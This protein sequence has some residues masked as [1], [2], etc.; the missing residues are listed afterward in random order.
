MHPALLVLKDL[1]SQNKTI[2]DQK[3]EQKQKQKKPTQMAIRAC[4]YFS[5]FPPPGGSQVKCWIQTNTSLFWLD[6]SYIYTVKTNFFKCKINVLKYSGGNCWLSGNHLIDLHNHYIVVL[7]YISICTHTQNE[8]V[9]EGIFCVV[10]QED[11]QVICQLWF[12]IKLLA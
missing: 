8:R 1:K 2:P 3:K 6:V 12:L 10:P 5:F 11:F 7:I 9:R 4:S